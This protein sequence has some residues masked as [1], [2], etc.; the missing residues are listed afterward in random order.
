MTYPARD[1]LNANNRISGI[2][3]VPSWSGADCCGGPFVDR[4]VQVRPS[5]G[6]LVC[7]LRVAGVDEGLQE[8]ARRLLLA[9]GLG[10]EA[11]PCKEVW[12]SLFTV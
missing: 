11:G 7:G 8:K 9:R 3:P 1:W 6:T 4:S 2:D 12:D 10:F 5:C